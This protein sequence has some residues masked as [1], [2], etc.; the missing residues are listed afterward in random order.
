VDVGA[1]LRQ[2]LA[3]QN[4][5]RLNVSRGLGIAFES[6]GVLGEGFAVLRTVTP[7]YSLPDAEATDHAPRMMPVGT[8]LKIESMTTV[9]GRPLYRVRMLRGRGPTPATWVYD[10]GHLTR[11]YAYLTAADIRH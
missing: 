4:L 8:R 10:T 7:L 6:A 9:S 11:G 1:D 2:T 5:L 3:M